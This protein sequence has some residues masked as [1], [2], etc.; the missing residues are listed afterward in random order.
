MATKTTL[1]TIQGAT[2]IAAFTADDGPGSDY[3]G[4]K[5]R[6]IV[7]KSLTTPNAQAIINQEF[8]VDPASG[9]AQYTFSDEISADWPVGSYVYA[10]VLID[11]AGNVGKTENGVFIVEASAYQGAIA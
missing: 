7:K 1:S 10:G 8:A 6:F 2:Y 4:W 3:T 5:V 11:A 9:L